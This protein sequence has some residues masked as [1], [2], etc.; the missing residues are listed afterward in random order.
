ME[1]FVND[2]G[3]NPEMVGFTPKKHTPK[4]GHF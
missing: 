4:F 3:G 1:G 2:M